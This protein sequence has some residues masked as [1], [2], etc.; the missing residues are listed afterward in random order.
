MSASEK[1]AYANY[2]FLDTGAW[3]TWTAAQQQEF[4]KAVQ[5]QKIPTPLTK[6]GDLGKDSRGV[7]LGTYT[8]A[9]YQ[10]YCERE[11]KLDGLR[12]KSAW[13]RRERRALKL[14]QEGTERK[15][16]DEEIEQERIRR[17]DIE[18]LQGK[19]MGRYEADP[20]WDDVVPIP[21]DDG[22][23]ALAAIAYTDEYAEGRFLPSSIIH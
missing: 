3:K 22:E 12:E 14:G 9:E 20:V 5:Q 7:D 23:G 18:Y 1:A 21:Q 17:R 2:R 4:W 15:V 16:T 10:T 11:S 13:F 6:P 19:S 8:P